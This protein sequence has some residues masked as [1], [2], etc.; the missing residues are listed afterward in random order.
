MGNMDGCDEHDLNDMRTLGCCDLGFEDTGAGR[1]IFDDFV[2]P[3]HFA[4]VAA[5]RILLSGA[6]ADGE[7]D[8]YELMMLLEDLNPKT[9]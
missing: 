6:L 4:K 8:A 1:T 5:F 7:D 3:R 9:L 2:T